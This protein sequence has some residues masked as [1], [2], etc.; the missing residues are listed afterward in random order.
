V[1]YK[2][3]G[4]TK[5]KQVTYEYDVFDRRIAKEVDDDGNGTVDRGEQ[6]AY[7][8]DRVLFRADRNGT[9]T[10]RYLHGLQVDQ[11][12][13]DESTTDGLLWA[14]ADHQRTVRD[15]ADY[16]SGTNTTTVA[17]HV[18]YDSFGRITA[19]SGG[20]HKPLFAY[21]GREWDA[22]AGMYYYRARWYES[23]LGRFASEDPMGFA[24]RD[25]NLARYVA[26]RP[27]TSTDSTGLQIDKAL[28]DRYVARAGQMTADFWSGTMA[29]ATHL[30][31]P[32]HLL[33]WNQDRWTDVS[34]HE[35]Y[36]AAVVTP[37]YAPFLNTVLMVDDTYDRLVRIARNGIN[38][39]AAPPLIGPVYQE[40]FHAWVDGVESTDSAQWLIDLMES[41]TQYREPRAMSEEAMSELISNMIDVLTTRGSIPKH[42]DA[43]KDP[44]WKEYIIPGHP[45]TW[46]DDPTIFIPMSREMYYATIYVLHNG[47]GNKPPTPEETRA[48]YNEQYGSTA[49]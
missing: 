12:F 4:G 7:D 23:A 41:Q 16:N 9:V 10:N 14:L 21:T 18:K 13:A 48:F 35:W 32:P 20:T 1:T 44:G 33:Q 22:D 46:E 47:E 27:T 31:L 49:N 39:L 26:N 43:L 19:Q 17:D 15:W 24:A 5:T 38:P 37:G 29:T 8:G 28:I 36:G 25:M 30:G 2:T 3:S 34:T 6:Y 40:A 42:E 11:V 45:E